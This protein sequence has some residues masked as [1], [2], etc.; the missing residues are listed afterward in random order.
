MKIKPSF[1]SFIRFVVP[2]LAIV[3]APFFS[4]ANIVGPYASD[5]NTRFLFHL[6]EA[7]GTSTAANSGGLGTNAYSVN[8][9]AS[10]T[11]PVT[12][13]VLG[14]GAFAGFGNSAAFSA[15]QSLIGWDFNNSGAYDG[16]TGGTPAG[17][18]KI[19][20][21]V[22]GM[23]GN[24]S[25]FTIEC[26]IYVT[27]TALNVQQ[28]FLANENTANRGMRFSLASGTL[29]FEAIT[30]SGVWVSAAV[31]TTGFHAW[32]ANTWYHVALTYDGTTARLYWT[33]VDPSITTA[34]LLA[35][36]TVTP[37]TA[38]YPA[39]YGTTV[40]GPFTIGGENRG[41]NNEFFRGRVD[42]VRVSSVA[43]A[44]NA[45][46]FYNDLT[47]TAN[48]VP[49]VAS[50]GG[51]GSFS[52]AA[53][54]DSSITNY[55]WYLGTPGSGT[56]VANGANVNGTIFSGE[57]TAT[58]GFSSASALD[59]GNTYYCNVASSFPTNKNSTAGLLTV[60]TPLNL[61]WRSTP[62]NHS[63][64]VG[65][66]DLNWLSGSPTAFFNGDNATFDNTGDSSTVSIDAAIVP[67]SVTVNN[68][69]Y[70][71]NGAGKITG[72][73]GLTK[74]GSG[75]LTISA[76]ND[77]TGV[78]IISG[79]TLSI[80]T[81]PTSGSAS[82][83]GAASSA[84][85]NVVFDGG[86]LQFT[87]GT[88]STDHGATLNAGGGT[89]SV[90][91]PNSLTMSGVIVGTSGGGLTKT[92]NGTLAL[93]GA[94]T[95]DGSTTIS[96]GTLQLS[97][98]GTFGAGNVTN[99]SS[100]L[101]SGSRNI[102]NNISG[103]GSL[104]NDA[105]GTLTLS[106]INNYTGATV[107]NG[108]NF[109][110]LT[111]ASSSALG[112]TA[113][114]VGSTTGGASGGTRVTLSPGVST[115][116]GASLSLPTAGTTVRSALAAAGASSWN[117]PITLNG[118]GAA[119]PSDQLAFLG[120]AGV[121]TVNGNVTGV[122]FPGTLQLRGGAGVINGTLNLGASATLQV[123]DGVAWTIG[124]TGNT[125]LISEI[126]SG[127]L[128]LGIN[129]AMPTAAIVKFG[130]AGNGTLDLNGFNQQVGSLVMV[131]GTDVITNSSATG[132]STLTFAGGVSS[133]GGTIKDGTRVIN[134][135]VTAGSL[136]LTNAASSY[137]GF[138][139]VAGGATNE[140]VY[141]ILATNSA[142]VVANGGT[143][144]LDFSV[145]NTVGS[146]VL[147]GA[148][149]PVGVYNN[150]TSPTFIT[151]PGSLQ[152]MAVITVN[153]TPTNLVTVVNGGNLELSWP[154]DHTG[155]RLQVQTN[156]LATGLNTN[157]SD[158]AGATTVN[159]VT[160]AINPANGAVFYRMVYP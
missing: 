146:L 9:T 47:I 86:T 30:G 25:P 112:N 15:S 116:A 119:S 1:A 155:W 144:K 156:S 103:T 62:A 16:E 98:G 157:W 105:T 2:L 73:T 45:M 43:R 57:T 27:N 39:A 44:A 126:A 42:E 104:T 84:S 11:V 99:N 37:G 68:A 8:A 131:G 70:T 77:Y 50:P 111:V 95:Y 128:Q 32:T 35:S 22:M 136:T 109:G 75:T 3:F 153:P 79:G 58:L 148:S 85:A 133:F 38:A 6:D 118:D 102:T 17:A 78:T 115:A 93:T 117:G 108:P 61:T 4:Q 97:G 41:G 154:A 71:L 88:G 12:T 34:N 160:N 36:A 48:P 83:I 101:C 96:G 139:S 5:A 145:T 120:N 46:L 10:A 137:H 134:L 66:V 106:G 7:A 23:N 142:V 129:N 19:T 147:G 138:T 121:L 67:S 82:P 54:S 122:N 135:S 123:N 87:G 60:H 92:S 90:S 69:S 91:S 132:D 76:T 124:S 21:S 51:S 29:Q 49:T 114:T 24:T 63:W 55:Q 40:R 53:T 150:T 89:V 94:N 113:V 80:A 13:A 151:G 31:P 130:A 59:S 100:L 125:W 107:I 149:Q 18:D 127:T 140:L 141:P 152:I 158:V 14:A 20:G 81:A 26:M 52:V 74:S 72:P 33:K 110:G 143:L 159:S 64:N 56:L 65:N 28:N